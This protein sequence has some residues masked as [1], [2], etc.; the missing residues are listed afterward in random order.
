MAPG[1]LYEALLGY[2][3]G[4][5]SPP[6]GRRIVRDERQ[7][8]HVAMDRARAV[9]R[10]HRHGGGLAASREDV[11]QARERLAAAAN[12]AERVARSWGAL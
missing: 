4:R 1:K 12:E 6:D 3:L 9:E 5:S 10:S 2:E 11:E 8:L 7:A